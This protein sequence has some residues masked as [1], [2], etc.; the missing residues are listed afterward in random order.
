VGERSSKNVPIVAR[1]AFFYLIG[2]RQHKS[3]KLIITPC[4]VFVSKHIS[5]TVHHHPIYMIL[6]TNFLVC[7]LKNQPSTYA[8]PAPAADLS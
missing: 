1:E 7:F 6:Y 5:I 4:L 3:G 2:K 8:T